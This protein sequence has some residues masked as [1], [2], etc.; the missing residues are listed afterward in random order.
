MSAVYTSN[1]RIAVSMMMALGLHAVILLGVGFAMD[2]K[3]L[4]GAF[5]VL[6]EPDFFLILKV[7]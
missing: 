6:S 2:F 5:I 3:P 1:D 4:T 7:R